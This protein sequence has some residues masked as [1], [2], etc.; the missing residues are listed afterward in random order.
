M[1][2]SIKTIISLSILF[3]VSCS[4]DFL[5]KQDPTQL[6][7]G[8]FYKTEAQFYQAVIGVYGQLQG[9]VGNQ[10]LFSEMITDNTTVHFNEGNRGPAA[11]EETFEYWYYNTSTAGVYDLYL[12]LYSVLGNVNLTLSKLSA[13]EN[14]DSDVKARFEGELRL[15]R[16]YYYFLLT[17]YFGDV[18]LITEPVK[19]PAEAISYDRSPVSNVYAV[20]ESDL[21]AAVEKLPIDAEPASV[22]RF[23]KGAA[24]SL[25]GLVSLTQKNYPKAK[26]LLDQVVAL[27]KY[28]LLP[29]YADVFNPNNKNNAESI[30]EVQFQGAAGNNNES[31]GFIYNFYPLFTN[32]EVTGFPNVS[33]AGF[34]I[35]T[36]DMINAYESGDSR[37]DLSLSEGYI[38]SETTEFVPVPFIEKFHHA[39]AIV[40]RPDDNWILFRYADV[41]LML[42][43]AINEQSGPTSEAFGYV[44]QV[45]QRAGLAD[46][47]GLSKE[48][49]RAAIL[50]ERRVELAFENHRWFDLRRIL[51]KTDLV[52]LLNAHG[53]AERANPTTP[54]GS[55]PFSAT[56][57]QFDEFEILFPIPARERVVKP[58]L[59]QNP[60]Y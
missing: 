38:N 58:D 29:G 35:P 4:E 42:A 50:Q 22:G 37:K 49:F 51:S 2:K 47:T 8:N 17:Q 3:L 19:N 21:N 26:Q 15:L 6:G 25:Y 39:H 5:N 41:L 44:N 56:D 34:N 36:R 30:L 16:G 12:D 32:G 1:K 31:S 54:R 14:I 59:A 48:Q 52:A 9:I 60:G 20:I 40:G 53:A 43:E 10:W 55:I 57:Y 11:N 28:S 45:R 27:G 23:T 7:E 46:I 18:I 13:S 33:G 24:L